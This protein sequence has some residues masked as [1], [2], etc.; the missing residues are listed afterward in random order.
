MDIFFWVINQIIEDVVPALELS[1]WMYFL[2]DQRFS[3]FIDRNQQKNTI[4]QRK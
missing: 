1:Y 2:V 4:R 3:L